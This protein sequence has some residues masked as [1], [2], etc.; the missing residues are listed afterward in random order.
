MHAFSLSMLCATLEACSSPLLVSQDRVCW[1]F[2]GGPDQEGSKA[3]TQRPGQ[4][5]EASG[6][7]A[8]HF[9]NRPCR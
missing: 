4:G 6:E 3:A 1:L 7:L 9:H 2:A 5:G 8:E